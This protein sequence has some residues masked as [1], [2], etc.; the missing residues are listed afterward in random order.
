MR[1]GS[2][3]AE[4]NRSPMIVFVI[5]IARY[6][7][8][9]MRAAQRAPLLVPTSTITPMKKSLLLASVVFAI[10]YLAAIAAQFTGLIS[11]NVFAV[12]VL[13]GGVIGSG[14]VGLVLSDYSRRPSFRVR[15]EKPVTPTELLP[16]TFEDSPTLWTY[17]TPSI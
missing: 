1:A 16:A 3:R 15:H 17:T 10:G 9:P 2:S 14:L 13:I 5:A 8:S 7:V 6:G 11:F 4:K 12:P